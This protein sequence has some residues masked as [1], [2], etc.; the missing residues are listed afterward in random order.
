MR[1]FSL[2]AAAGTAGLAVAAPATARTHEASAKASTSTKTPKL[3]FWGVNESGAEFGSNAWPGVYNKDYTWYNLSTYDIFIARGMNY[4][5]VN[6]LNERMAPNGL[7]GALDSAYLG[8]LTQQVNYIT[9]KGATAFITPHNYGRYKGQVVDAASYGT[10]WKNLAGHFKTNAKVVFDVDN[11][12]HDMSQTLVVQ[13]NQAAI[14]GIRSAG[15]TTQYITPE[16]NAWTGAWSWTTV[17]DSTTGKT[18]GQTMGA[19]TDASNKLIYQMHQYLDSD[20]SGT[21]ATCVNSTILADRLVDATNWLRTN[22]KKGLI[23]EFAGG[24]NADCI[25]ALTG[26]LQYMIKNS[27][28]WMGASLWA[29]GPWWGTYIFNLEPT[30]AT[31]IYT[32]VLPQL[33]KV[34]LG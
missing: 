32:Q 6:I 20:S 10:Y 2:L 34:V 23:G 13:I 29:A 1:F 18:N 24:N 7:T 14:N 9:S 28:V 31:D 21:S 27:D 25:A 17:A 4:F 15:A 33:E 8:N 26:G 16:G 11:E 12:F 5:R 3:T 19:L 22:K 30:Q